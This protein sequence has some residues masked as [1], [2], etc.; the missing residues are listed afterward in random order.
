MIEDFTVNQRFI[1]IIAIFII[2][3]IIS[4]F[5]TITTFNKSHSEI[6]HPS[7][8]K[9]KFKEDFFPCQRD[10]KSYNKRK[11]KGYELMMNKRI[12]IAG[13]GYNI[14]YKKAKLLYQRLEYI[15]QHFKSC[16]ILYYGDE[17][18]DGSC[19]Y[20][21]RLT[22]NTKY[23]NWIFIDKKTPKCKSERFLRMAQLR[24]NYLDYFKKYCNHDYLMIVDFDLNGPISLDG[25]ADSIYYIDHGDADV[26]F[27]NGIYSNGTSLNVSWLGWTYYDTL[28]TVKID[29]TKEL[30]QKWYVGGQ[31]ID[32]SRGHDLIPVI[33]G[34]AGAGIYKAEIF[35]NN[36]YHPMEPNACEHITLHQLMYEDGYKLAINPS[37]L[38]LSGIQGG[39]DVD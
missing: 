39:T 6:V 35:D 16:D 37:L 21:R 38:L 20:L 15:G 36:Y 1:R 24:N 26:I 34:F 3:I 28:A 4:I 10:I 14:G 12:A 22:S 8:Y 23:C 30:D 27:A 9:V 25:I 32:K 17:S 29:T 2:I 33:S 19:D 18:T 5:I 13:L 11:R 31:R 7:L